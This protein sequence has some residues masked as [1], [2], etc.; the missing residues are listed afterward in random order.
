MDSGTS[1]CSV[2]DINQDYLV[3]V[4]IDFGTTYSGYAFSFLRE[5]DQQIHLMRNPI[6]S[7]NLTSH[8][9]PTAILLTPNGK[10]F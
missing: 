1:S 5:A 8:K 9:T 3:V 6:Q 7:N 10:F 2:P 4:A